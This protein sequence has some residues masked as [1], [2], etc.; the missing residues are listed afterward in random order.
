M[1]SPFST[2]DSRTFTCDLF[3]NIVDQC[4]QLCFKYQDERND[5]NHKFSPISG[6]RMDTGRNQP[7]DCQF[8]YFFLIYKENRSPFLTTVSHSFIFIFSSIHLMHLLIFESHNT[9]SL[10]V[11]SSFVNHIILLL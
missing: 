4:G 10:L 7:T 11:Y 5:H 1:I 8:P 6:N 3:E 9:F 2:L